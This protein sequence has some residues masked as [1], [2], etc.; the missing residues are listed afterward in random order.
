MSLYGGIDLHSNNHYLVILDKELKT[1]FQRRLRNDLGEVLGR[2]EPYREEIVGIAV[3]STRNWYWLV[4]GLMEAGYRVH[5]TNTSAVQQY[6]GLKYTDDRSDARWLARLLCLGILPEGYIYPKEQRPW[7]DLLRR[8]S[9]L[10]HKR[11]SLLLS[12]GATYG[13]YTGVR[14]TASEMKQWTVREV[15][16]LCDDP[17]VAL[18]MSSLCCGSQRCCRLRSDRSRRP[19]SPRPS[20]VR[21]F[22]CSGPCEG[23]GR[24]SRLRLCTRSGTSGVSPRWGTLPPTAGA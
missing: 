7:R 4:D 17:R 15:E 6:E 5:L 2:L 1:V 12:I 11:T 3:E 18:S 10:V 14:V 8:R 16:S 19:W 21:S 24:R 20:C 22:T 23:S 13:Q 9:F